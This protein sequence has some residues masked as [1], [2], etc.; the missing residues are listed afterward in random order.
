MSG[1]KIKRYLHQISTPSSKMNGWALCPA[2]ENR[3][4]QVHIV[5]YSEGVLDT[6]CCTWNALKPFA[7]AIYCIGKSDVWLDVK[8]Q[9]IE[10]GYPEIAAL[11]HH[12][13]TPRYIGNYRTPSPGIPLLILQGKSELIK[14]KTR[15]RM[16]GY[17]K[18]WK[19]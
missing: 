15:L 3:I 6:I 13:N 17:Y 4:D 8:C 11:W 19:N 14:E 7:V 2:L 18:S 16:L 10:D 12:P 1:R 5:E 9:E